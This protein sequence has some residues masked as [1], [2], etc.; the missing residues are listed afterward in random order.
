MN[1]F[2]ITIMRTSDYQLGIDA[3]ED[4]L[5]R[6]TNLRQAHLEYVGKAA[7]GT[8]AI[9]YLRA[10]FAHAP[11][12]GHWCNLSKAYRAYVRASL[13]HARLRSNG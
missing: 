4:L 3:Y 11:R 8:A 5:D 6:H 7:L 9:P 12:K 13:T 2:G 1:I 10:R